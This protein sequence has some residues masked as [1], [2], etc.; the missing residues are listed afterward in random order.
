MF[1]LKEEEDTGWVGQCSCSK[2]LAGTDTAYRAQRIEQ[3]AGAWAS[4]KALFGV[5]GLGVIT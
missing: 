3:N 4:A 2:A 1:W 5:I